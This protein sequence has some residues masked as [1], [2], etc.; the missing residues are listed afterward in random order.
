MPTCSASQL[1]ISASSQGQY[2][3]LDR[4]QETNS[5][6][7][8][9]AGNVTSRRQFPPQLYIL[10]MLEC[11]GDTCTVTVIRDLHHTIPLRNSSRG[12]FVPRHTMPS[13]ES[14]WTMERSSVYINRLVPMGCRKK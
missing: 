5:N 7:H 10:G 1:T 11:L 13:F 14:V 9:E 3:G 12:Y 8:T 4:K 2:V 6:S